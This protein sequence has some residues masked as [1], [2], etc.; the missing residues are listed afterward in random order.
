[1]KGG[2][3]LGFIGLGVM[4]EPI[5]A[6]LARG[7]GLTVTAF[8]SDASKLAG[9][10]AE[11]VAAAADAQEVFDASD[12]VF[13]SLPSGEIVEQVLVASGLANSLQRGQVVVDLGTTSVET[14]RKI[15]DLFRAKGATFVDA[16]VARTRK[17]AE[18]GKLS[19]MVGA[20]PQVFEVIEPY[21]GTF[22]SDITLCGGTG[23][24]QVVKILNNT[25]L[26]QTVVA[27]SEA[28]AV[29][30]RAGVDPKVLFETLSKGSADSFALRNHGMKAMLPGD[31][32]SPAFSVAYARKDLCYSLDLARELGVDTKSAQYVDRLFEAAI[33]AGYGDLYWPVI[34]KLID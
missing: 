10:G 33:E 5:C 6:N 17:A 20:D 28:K 11:G 7:A 12:I 19:V 8:D 32:P 21:L 4:G 13:L 26:F 27:L 25:I 23:A 24:G 15:A 22:A 16:P 1:M 14:T 18:E 29:G 3:R 34:C 31:F 30:A 9:L 2:H